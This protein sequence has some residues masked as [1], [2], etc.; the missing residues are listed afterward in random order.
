MIFSGDLVPAADIAVGEVWTCTFTPDDGTE[1]GD[2][3]SVSVTVGDASSDYSGDWELDTS[4]SY[5][6]AWGLVSI[7][8]GDI[9]ITDNYPDIE[10][11]A[12]GSQP[13]TMS[14]SYTSSS[15]FDVDNTLYGSCDE[16]Y[17][18]TGEFTDPN[19]LEATF[20]ITF[21]GSCYDCGYYSLSFTATR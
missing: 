6:C 1:S 14:G 9:E 18:L 3:G 13:G 12:G 2:S 16:I 21:S 11:K 15:E 20:E 7:G 19:T 17:E 10:I 5:S 4:V 8:F